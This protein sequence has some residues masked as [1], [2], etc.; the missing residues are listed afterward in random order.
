MRHGNYSMQ[1]EYSLSRTPHTPQDPPRRKPNRDAFDLEWRL[2]PGCTKQCA[3]DLV[4]LVQLLSVCAVSS[5]SASQARRT[6]NR[7]RVM[8]K[9][10]A[11]GSGSDY[12]SDRRARRLVDRNRDEPRRASGQ[13]L[14]HQG[15]SRLVFDTLVRLPVDAAIWSNALREL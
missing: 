2:D 10:Q 4:L 7:T 6:S 11:P 3:M 15:T 8:N 12:S 14:A 9:G 1:P 5:A 13:G